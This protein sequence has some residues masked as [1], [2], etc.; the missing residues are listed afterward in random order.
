MKT[1]PYEVLWRGKP[2][3]PET[4]ARMIAYDVAGFAPTQELVNTLRAWAKALASE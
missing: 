1:D 4:M 3:S 2:K